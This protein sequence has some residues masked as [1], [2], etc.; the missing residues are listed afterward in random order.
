MVGVF[1][2]CLYLL[3]VLQ[4]RADPLVGVSSKKPGGEYLQLAG[5]GH[6]CVPAAITQLSR[7]HSGKESTCRRRRPKRLGFDLWLGKIPWRKRWST[8]FSSFPCKI[9]WTEKPGGLQSMG[10]E[11]DTTE[12]PSVYTH[13]PWSHKTVMHKCMATAGFGHCRLWLAHPGSIV[14]S[15]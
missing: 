13:T 9:P 1:R 2:K 3:V 5:P 12:R 11:S 6:L 14:F 15:I 4:P 8:H 7:Q 10:S